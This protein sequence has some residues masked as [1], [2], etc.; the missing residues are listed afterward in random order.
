MDYFDLYTGSRCEL[1]IG[2]AYFF[3]ESQTVYRPL[4]WN[5]EKTF[6][7]SAKYRNAFVLPTPFANTK[8]LKLFFFINA[9]YEP[10][11]GIKKK[12]NNEE[13]SK[14]YVYKILSQCLKNSR[15]YRPQ[16]GYKVCHFTRFSP[17]F[18]HIRV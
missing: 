10:N 15:S 7:S 16:K 5:Q 2:V 12:K 13:K 14:F 6:L 17:I 11:N 1:Q 8:Y 3:Q 18:F 4:R 9:S